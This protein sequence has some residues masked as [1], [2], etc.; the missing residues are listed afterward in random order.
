MLDIYFWYIHVQDSFTVC[1]CD[2]IG[3]SVCVGA[4]NMSVHACVCVCM[5][6]CMR[7]CLCVNYMVCVCVCV[8]YMVCDLWCVGVGVGVQGCRN[9][10]MYK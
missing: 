9:T 5:R 7:V 1:M 10:H 8:N 3:V 6:A 4:H 2:K